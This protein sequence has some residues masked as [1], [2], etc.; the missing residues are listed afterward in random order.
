MN[1]KGMTLI[2]LV[3]VVA[4][5]G[6]L[7]SLTYPSYSHYVL[8]AHRNAIQSD[9]ARIQLHLEQNYLAGYQLDGILS[10]GKCLICT[11]DASRYQISVSASAHSYTILAQ[12]K[13]ASGQ[14]LDRCGQSSYQ[15]LTLSHN[16]ISTPDECW[17]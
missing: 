14:H 3:I 7:A 8:E 11:S 6:V 9:M 12:P 16:G 17:R 5:I 1:C 10:A 2:E 15:Q 13:T 4:I